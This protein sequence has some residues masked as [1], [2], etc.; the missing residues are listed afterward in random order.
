MTFKQIMGFV[1]LTAFLGFMIYKFN[2]NISGQQDG[3]LIIAIAIIV[4]LMILLAIRK[5]ILD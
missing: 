4:I 2:L 1:Y 5:I 3:V